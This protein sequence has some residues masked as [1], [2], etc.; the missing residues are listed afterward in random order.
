MRSTAHG[1]ILSDVS[2][3]LRDVGAQAPP[4]GGPFGVSLAWTGDQPS[5]T[6][7]AILDLDTARDWTGFR[8]AASRFAVPAQNLVYADI[9]GNIGYQAPGRIPIR[10]TGNDG[11]VALGRLRRPADDWTG[12]Y[13]PF[14]ALPSVLDPS[15]GFVVTANQA[16][17]G[18]RLPLLPD[19]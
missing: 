11:Q 1:P 10:R 4:A 2:S 16:V 13:V 19:P 15:D 14:R 8:R 17:T 3:D 18:Q 9:H 5:R 12:R 7:D 6:A